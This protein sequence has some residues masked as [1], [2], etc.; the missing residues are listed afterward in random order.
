MCF[1]SLEKTSFNVKFDFSFGAKARDY[2]NLHDN[3]D[4]LEG[5]E[6]QA[7]IAKL[8]IDEIE[9]ENKEGLA[10]MNAKQYMGKSNFWE[11][12]FSC[13][14]AFLS[15]GLTYIQFRVIKNHLNAKKYL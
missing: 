8:F 2:G 14:F 5:L 12:L 10:I 6:N 7:R 11:Y 4:V 9:K 1:T 13:L 3:K 15:I